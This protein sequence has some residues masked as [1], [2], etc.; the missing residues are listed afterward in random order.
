MQRLTASETEVLELSP[1]DI[2][3]ATNLLNELAEIKTRI[4]DLNER[5]KDIIEALEMIFSQYEPGTY[6]IGNFTVKV[7]Q[8]TKIKVG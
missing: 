7:S 8:Q 4:K 3:V 1:R 2:E 6:R 5:K